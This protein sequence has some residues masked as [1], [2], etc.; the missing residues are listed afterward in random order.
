MINTHK[1]AVT[2]VGANDKAIEGEYLGKG[3]LSVTHKSRVLVLLVMFV[4]SLFL[5]PVQAMAAIDVSGA[6][7]QFG[8]I[9]TAVPLIGAAFLGALALM[10]VWKLAR[11]L[12]A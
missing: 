2:V 4:V 10:A 5:V 9:N 7:T 3:S 11:G 1:N 12:F 8:E 6:V